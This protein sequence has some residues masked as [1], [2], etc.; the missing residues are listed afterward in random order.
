M[1]IDIGRESIRRDNRLSEYCKGACIRT[2]PVIWFNKGHAL[3][4]GQRPPIRTMFPTALSLR[5]G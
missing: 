5:R 4:P 1:T 2:L 3:T